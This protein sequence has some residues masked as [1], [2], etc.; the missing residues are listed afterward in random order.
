[1]CKIV[2]ET[3]DV[4]AL[5]GRI[6]SRFSALE[7]R[8]ARRV[9]ALGIHTHTHTH[10]HTPAPSDADIYICIPG[11]MLAAAVS[12]RPEFP[13]A[14]FLAARGGGGGGGGARE[15][16]GSALAVLSKAGADG[17]RVVAGEGCVDGLS[18]AAGI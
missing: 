16:N 18:V 15:G 10:T 8:R 14:M 17:G 13:S 3:C 4:H 9:D 1:M 2:D 5:V 7:K 11:K 12:R 6:V